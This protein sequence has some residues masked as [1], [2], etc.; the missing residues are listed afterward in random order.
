MRQLSGSGFSA[1]TDPADAPC[2]PG[3]RKL[4]DDDE[5]IRSINAERA[6]RL[7]AVAARKLAY[8]GSGRVARHSLSSAT[9][10]C[11]SV[12][13]RADLGGRLLGNDQQVV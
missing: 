9:I 7:R 5:L 10:I 6:S 2:L 12:G 11:S 4:S 1:M 3:I 13:H 8:H